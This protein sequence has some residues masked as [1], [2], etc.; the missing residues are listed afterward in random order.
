MKDSKNNIKT[1]WSTIRS[2]NRKNVIYNNISTQQWYD[3]FHSVFNTFDT[4]PF[5]NSVN[6]EDNEAENDSNEPL[7]HDPITKEEVVAG[8]KKLKP[9]KSCGSDKILGEMLKLGNAVELTI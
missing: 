6:V 9:G 5:D 7:F 4:A 3:H 2:V 1:F 8:V